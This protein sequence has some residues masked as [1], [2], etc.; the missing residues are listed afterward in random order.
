MYIEYTKL[1]KFIYW[2]YKIV[3]IIWK[4]VYDLWHSVP[5][6]YQIC[7]YHLKKLKL[8]TLNIQKCVHSS[9]ICIYWIYKIENLSTLNIQNC[10]LK[11]KLCTLFQVASD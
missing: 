10:V 8:C 3:Y 9:K 11:Y 7:V 1:K 2:I 4:F 5:W 6:M